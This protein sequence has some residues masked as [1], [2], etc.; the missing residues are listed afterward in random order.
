MY[1]GSARDCMQSPAMSA[2]ASLRN[3]AFASSSSRDSPHATNRVHHQSPLLR[4]QCLRHTPAYGTVC[5]VALPHRDD[6]LEPSTATTDRPKKSSSSSSSNRNPPSSSLQSQLTNAAL[7]GD[8]DTCIYLLQS[9]SRAHPK[10][11][12]SMGLDL[13]GGV[14]KQLVRTCFKRKRGH[15]ALEVVLALPNVNKRQ[16]SVLMKECIDRGDVKQLDAVLEARAGVGY[17]AD[18]YTHSARISTL[19]NAKR[20]VAALEQLHIA[21][22]DEACAHT[23]E[24][25][26][27]AI[28]ACAKAGDFAGAMTVWGLVAEDAETTPDVVTYN[29]MIKLSGAM[30]KFE[31]VKRYFGMITE[32]GLVPTS[33]TYA[34]V[35]SASAAC[36]TNDAGFLIGVFDSME[37]QP[38]DFIL[39][40]FFTAMSHS[41]CSKKD[42]DVV[43]RLLER[44]RGQ[45]AELIDVTYTAFMTFL[46]RQVGVC[47]L[48]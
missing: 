37:V 28:S 15:K 19:G 33:W 47:L 42:I 18:V 14:L 22:Q 31:D 45:T 44:S 1:I 2:S 26:N 36:R 7:F 12:S 41:R 39:S 16:F 11:A 27:A 13:S 48:G 43:F 24:L 34:A 35:F 30:G 32:D 10:A 17:G 40:S 5:R 3:A 38:N 25:Y 4:A 9:G 23:I 20:S 29:A 46:A 6:G 8:V 21:M